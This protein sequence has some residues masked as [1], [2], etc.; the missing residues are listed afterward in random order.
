[1]SKWPQQHP[2]AG[3]ALEVRALRDPV[4]LG[5]RVNLHTAFHVVEHKNKGFQGD[6]WKPFH[7]CTFT[8]KVQKPPKKRGAG[9][10]R[11]VTKT[12]RAAH[13]EKC[14]RTTDRGRE[15]D[16]N[17]PYSSR[18]ATNVTGPNSFGRGQRMRCRA[19]GR[20]W[21]DRQTLCSIY[22]KP[23]GRQPAGRAE[24]RKGEHTS[25]ED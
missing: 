12:N 18:F 1:M 20:R 10:G 17:A 14:E 19:L 7:V 2:P 9:R 4:F 15:T 13:R 23:V 11:G 22:R 8:T 21:T 6:H 3:G 25:A 5:R 24:A 16:R